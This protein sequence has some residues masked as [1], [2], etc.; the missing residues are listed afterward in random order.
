MPVKPV[1]LIIRDGWGYNPNPRGNSVFTAQTPVVD[2]LKARY[3]WTLLDA[4]G[5]AVGLPDGYQGSSEVGHLNMGAGRIV[6]QELK[7]IDD[8]LRD[9]SLFS[10]EQWSRVV[11]N[12]KQNNS[13]LHL[14]GLLQD[15][16]VHAHQE[17][18]FK[19]MRRA[20]QDYPEGRVVIHPFLDGRDTP[21]RS[22]AEYIAKLLK[23]IDEIG[24]CVIGTCMGRYYAMDRSKNWALTDEAYA[25]IVSAKGRPGKDILSAV[26]ES[27]A[28]DKT[29]DGTEMVDEYIP[30]YILGD[31]AAVKDG[32]SVL[33]TD[34]RQDRAIQ[35]TMAFV[36]PDYA[37]T[38]SAKPKVVYVGLTRYYDSFPYFMLGAMGADGGMD[39]LLGEVVAK[40]GHKQLRIAETQKFRHVTSFFNGKSTTP[41]E[42]EDQVEVKGRFDP[43]TFASHPEMEAEIVTDELLKRIKDN[44]Y[45]MIVVNY[46]NGDMVGHTGD[47]AAAKKAVETVD[48]CLGRLVP[49]LLELDA[50]I[51][52]TADHGNA[53][54]MVDY[55][56][57]MT[58]TSHT[59]FPVECIYVAKD[60]WDKHLKERGK[61]SDLAP[62]ML[63]LMGLP[64]PKEMSAD[65]LIKD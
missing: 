36:D 5:E 29:P 13:S 35:L 42:N 41:F 55:E 53:E 25:A 32:D 46:A 48:A 47:P 34:N 1:V 52:I 37:G 57:G 18:L 60:S 31:Y 21:P 4:S 64:V 59:L 7:R 9:G 44:P 2:R 20:R 26:K 54:Q 50:D 22:S 10:T 24:N 39:N 8:G 58:K 23:V 14:L 12:W 65:V 19:I 15:E 61:L 17:H 56:T 43:A 33:H 16:G 30:P 51:L 63:K 28:K 40:H 3:P 38:L 45:K 49:A 11:D 27:Y 6:I 62:T